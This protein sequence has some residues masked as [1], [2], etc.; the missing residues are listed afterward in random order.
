MLNHT[1]VPVQIDHENNLAYIVLDPKPLGDRLRIELSRT[2][3]S[4]RFRDVVLDFDESGRLVGIEL[5]D[6]AA[7]FGQRE[8]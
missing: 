7:V 3:R 8:G 5:L 1:S 6:A 2:G 4:V